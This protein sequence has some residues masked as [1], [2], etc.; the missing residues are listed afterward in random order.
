ML[1][2]TFTHK[3]P[4]RGEAYVVKSLTKISCLSG[5]QFWADTD[6]QTYRQADR[7]PDTHT[8]TNIHRHTHTHTHTHICMPTTNDYMY[9]AVIS[10]DQFNFKDNMRPVS[11]VLETPA[12]RATGLLLSFT[13][14]WLSE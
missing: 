9:Y 1:F 10:T 13:L 6:R 11:W 5:T 12:S 3:G 2:L 7:D 8:H 14:V 4:H